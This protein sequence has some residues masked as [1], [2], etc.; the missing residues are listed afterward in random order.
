MEQILTNRNIPLNEIDHYLNTA[1]TDINPP[2][3]LG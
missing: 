2:E 3:A 1:D